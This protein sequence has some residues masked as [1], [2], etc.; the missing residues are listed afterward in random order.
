[1]VNVWAYSSALATAAAPDLAGEPPQRLAVDELHRHVEAIVELAGVE[2][3]DDARMVE[4]RRGAHLVEEHVPVPGGVPLLAQELERDDLVEAARSDQARDVDVGHAA[5][6]PPRQEP[7]ARPRVDGHEPHRSARVGAPHVPR[8][9]ARI[10]V[11][12]SVEALHPR[13]FNRGCD[14]RGA[15]KSR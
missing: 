9:T 13:A 3:L 10:D 6:P 14:R 2:R 8:R 11:L 15:R 4:Q 5:A 7:V 1:L 12:R